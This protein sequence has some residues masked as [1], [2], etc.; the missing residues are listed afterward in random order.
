MNEFMQEAINEARKG[1][2][3]G[4]G[5]PFGCVIVRNGKIVAK[6]HNEVLKR[7]DATCHSE[8]RAIQIASRKLRKYNLSDCE[9]YVT[10]K[11]CPMCKAAIL[12]A[13][14]PKIYYGCTY[15]DAKEIGFEE[16]LGNSTEYIETQLDYEDC[17]EVYEDYKNT[18]HTLY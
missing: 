4:H 12:W 10:G 2:R 7:K 5:G 15:G 16:E 11:P 13:K 1:I 17:K 3:R 14:I 8:I 18:I 9:L 6:A